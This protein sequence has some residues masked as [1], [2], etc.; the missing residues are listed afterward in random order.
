M[1]SCAPEETL[2]TFSGNLKIF[3]TPSTC[4]DSLKRPTYAR[5]ATKISMAVVIKSQAAV[6]VSFFGLSS[7][8]IITG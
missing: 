6:A 1:E 5:N 8:T 4:G 7:K 3:K 2:T